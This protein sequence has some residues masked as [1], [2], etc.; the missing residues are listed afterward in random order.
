VSHHLNEGN[1]RATARVSIRRE[2]NTTLN[3]ATAR[4]VA[5]S[6]CSG[7]IGFGAGG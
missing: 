4:S 7:G 3:Y 5:E 2:R 6:F 1:Y